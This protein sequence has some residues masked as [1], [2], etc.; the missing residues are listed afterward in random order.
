MNKKNKILMGCLALLLALSVGYAL[1][2]DTIT[3]NGIATAKGEFEL[4]TTCDTNEVNAQNGI[5]TAANIT[6]EGNVVDATATLG[7]PGSDKWFRVMVKNTGTIPAKIKEVKEL[8]NP[9]I[10]YCRKNDCPGQIE[11]TSYIRNE[12]GFSTLYSEFY[13]YSTAWDDYSIN[14]E[15]FDKG[16]VA[17]F[18]EEVLGAVLDPEETA[19]FYVHMIWHPDSVLQDPLTASLKA[20]LTWEQVTIE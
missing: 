10:F 13:S 6:C 18:D 4:T 20:E 9:E 5:V 15:E 7:A 1:F 8:N 17:L 14:V 2:S 3:I 12:E 16:G 11:N 19:Y